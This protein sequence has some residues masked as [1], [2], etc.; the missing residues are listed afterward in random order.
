MHA[1]TVMEMAGGARALVPIR[2][3]IRDHIID[4][5]SLVALML[6]GFRLKLTAPIDRSAAE[7]TCGSHTIGARRE[8]AKFPLMLAGQ[9]LFD[10]RVVTGSTEVPFHLL[11][12]ATMV[13]AVNPEKPSNRLTVCVLAS[14][15][16]LLVPRL[17][18]RKS[19]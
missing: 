7:R 1:I 13:E 6:N 15:S 14:K 17:I 11:A 4:R 10:C 9:R 8:E 12:G 16:G 5:P 3:A 2:D 18:S 19:P